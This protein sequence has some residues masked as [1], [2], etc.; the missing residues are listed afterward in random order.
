MNKLFDNDMGKKRGIYAI[1]NRTKNRVYVG[2]TVGSFNKRYSA[3]MTSFRQKINNPFLQRDYEL[4]SQNFTMT[5]LEVIE[6]KEDVIA[7][8]QKWLDVLFDDQICCYNIAPIAGNTSGI[9]FTEARKKNLAIKMKMRLCDPVYYASF[10]AR[11]NKKRKVYE[12]IS[13]TNEEYIG[14]GIEQFC[15]DHNLS[16]SHMCELVQGSIQ[17]YRG[18]RLLSNKQYIFDRDTLCKNNSASKVATLDIQIM[19]PQGT[20]YGPITN[21]AEFCR[22]HSLHRIS[23]RNLAAGKIKQTKGWKLL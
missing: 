21:I 18:W 11:Q 16:V 3:H 1:Q 8:E 9:H 19:S 12:F 2:S 17:S 20:I 14:K 7:V 4:D 13:P 15:K 5:V 22:E 10:L 23:V 6:S